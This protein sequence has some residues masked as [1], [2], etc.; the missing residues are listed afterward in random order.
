MRY[1]FSVIYLFFLPIISQG[2]H[3][4]F[5]STE[6]GL[7]SSSI[8]Q[9]SQDDKGYIWVSTE[10]GTCEFDGMTFTVF[11][12]DDNDSTSISSD[13]SK[14]VFTDSRGGV[15]VGTSDG[16]QLFDRDK[17]LFHYLE[18]ER[19]EPKASIYISSIA[20]TRDHKHV[21][22]SASG[23]GLM[24]Y[25]L[26]TYKLNKTLVDVYNKATDLRYPGLLFID[27]ENILWRYSEQGAIQRINMSQFSI[28]EPRWAD[29]LK[30]QSSEFVASAI[31][32][33]PVNK[34]II[35]GTF[36]HGLFIYDRQLGYIRKPK[37][38]PNSNCRIRSLL[39]EQRTCLKPELQIWV[40]MEE[41]GLMLFDRKTETFQKPIF[42]YTPLSLDN[43]KVHSLIQD[44]QGN[45][46]AGIMQK[47]IVVVPR[48]AN[49]FEYIKLAD[50]QSTTD[51]NVACATSIVADADSNIWIA[52]DGG[53][54]FCIDKNGERQ[55]FTTQNANLPN[56]AILSLAIDKRGSIWIST[57]TGG[58]T[59]YS[60]S[61]GFKLFNDDVGLQRAQCMY[62]D[63]SNDILYVGTLG[64]GVWSISLTDNK[65]TQIKD[66]Y[67]WIVSLTI[68]S[69]GLMW[70]G[71]TEGLCC[72]NLKTKKFE[73]TEFTDKLKSIKVYGGVEDKEQ[74]IYWFAS[75]TGL[76]RWNYQTGE[77]QHYTTKEGLPD[78]LLTSAQL[79]T[80]H[81]L[82]LGSGNGLSY[83]NTQTNKFCNF[84]VNDGLQDNEFRSRSTYLAQDGKMYFG[85]I[86]GVTAFYPENIKQQE[87]LNSQ[88]Y[89]SRL[90]VMNK[91]VEYDEHKGNDNILDSHISQAKQ[92]TLDYKDNVF[93]LMFSVLEY[94]NPTNV[95]YAY[96]LEG[97]D[98]EWR[99]TTPNNRSATYTNLPFGDYKFI[100][101]AFREGFEK[102]NSSSVSRSINIRI[103]PPWYRSWWAYIIYI[104]VLLT[105]ARQLYLLEKRRKRRNAELIEMD[106]K[107]AKLRL[108]TDMSHEI[109]TPLSLVISPLKA[110]REQENN[111]SR[112]DM[113]DLMYR[114]AL[115]VIRL[116][117]QLIDIRKFDNNQLKMKFQR[118]EIFDFLQDIMKSFDQLAITRNVDLR[119]ISNLTSLGVWIDAENF[120]KVIFN[121]LSNAFKFTPDNGTVMLTIDTVDKKNGDNYVELA[122]EN[123]GSHIN[124]AELEHIF[125]R[126]YQSKSNKSVGGSGIGLHLAK[127]IVEAH[128]GTIEAR[129][130]DDGV[131]FVIRLPLGNAHLSKDEMI[132]DESNNNMQFS[133]SEENTYV[134]VPQQ[135]SDDETSITSRAKVRTIVFVDDDDEWTSFIRNSLSD[136]YNVEICTN[137]SDAWRLIQ[138]SLPDAVVTDLMM[139]EIDGLDICRKIRQ[140]S[141]LSHLPIIILTSDGDEETERKC[142]DAG[143]DNFLTKPISIS[144]LKTTIA[145]AISTR[146]MLRNKYRAD[147]KSDFETVEMTSPDSRLI[148]KVIEAIRNNIEN[149][150]FGVDDL[151]R[152]VGIS[153][154]H[155]N[156]KLK[157]TLNTS[158]SNLIKSIRLKQAAYL[159]INNKLNVS[160]VA[161]K[162]GYSSHSYFSNNFKE[163]FG[164]SPTDFVLKYSGED[165]ENIYKLF[166][167]DE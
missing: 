62:Y 151:S 4:R 148:A 7:S 82:W 66:L 35:I 75:Q 138:T 76:Y 23:I 39:A 59:C 145:H 160:D 73:N 68:D 74:N 8:N 167:L 141:E 92:I 46:W 9:L 139:P 156:R 115:R 150:N 124:E 33:D 132:I 10:N 81:C 104:V 78:N 140:S 79:D 36:N 70:V 112:R 6:Q 27:S 157:E 130:A 128:H 101:K 96:R 34:N 15:W 80:K 146:D 100:V 64:H 102:D 26:D 40:G 16:L 111:A 149:S 118:I 95:I 103:L 1:F 30:T 53:G 119:I 158:P 129:N 57:Y 37:G 136:K 127:M 24:V 110:L 88:L 166:G 133:R 20:E 163:Y 90:R 65:I 153:R 71:R 86:N 21:L 31:V 12:H 25:N 44:N 134:D 18:V 41:N 50:S 13:L 91:I 42:Q 93:T 108:F 47:G 83:Y 147:A 77:M 131:A 43:C 113:L 135:N 60:K 29:E 52:S 109:R 97:F 69:K 17:N 58:I 3:I 5:Y 84:H 19:N 126:F 99:Y 54:L 45:V 32:E 123:S 48:L 55:R 114:N 63:E 137:P 159:L 162:L 152:E 22:V 122:I 116:L 120:D 11:R 117:N 28:E 49:N 38:L 164:M 144:L 67:G 56:N 155:L 61:K 106:K 85:G 14:V 161:Y 2:Q 89:F 143:A 98:K 87:P 94:L 165:K 121:I 105:L 107:E 125:E 72:Y 51:V 142:I 154:V